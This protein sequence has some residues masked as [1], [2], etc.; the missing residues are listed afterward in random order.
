MLRKHLGRVSTKL[1]LFNSRRECKQ[2]TKV[3]TLKALSTSTWNP[4][5]DIAGST[6]EAKIKTKEKSGSYK[7][8]LIKCTVRPVSRTQCTAARKVSRTQA[9]LSSTRQQQHKTKC[10][11][12]PPRIYF[13]LQSKSYILTHLVN[14]VWRPGFCCAG[15]C[16]SIQGSNCFGGV[17]TFLCSVHSKVIQG[18]SQQ[19]PLLM[20]PELL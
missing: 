3:L 16:S 20:W 13:I 6:K 9:D 12:K 10:C 7:R 17:T 11:F 15:V 4:A 18:V 5:T 1:P 14:T 8:C 19:P 2:L